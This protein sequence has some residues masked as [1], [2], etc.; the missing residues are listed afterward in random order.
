MRNFGRIVTVVVVCF[1][2][3]TGGYLIGFEK[4][5]ERGI[6]EGNLKWEETARDRDLIDFAIGVLG[7]RAEEEKE[8]E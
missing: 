7:E 2:L 5:Y 8:E 4:G 1:G 3:W 6:R